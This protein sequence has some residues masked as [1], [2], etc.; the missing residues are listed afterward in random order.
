[1]TLAACRCLAV[2]CVLLF[3]STAVAQESK[4]QP[5]AKQLAAALDAAKLDS[6][7]APDPSTPGVFVGVLYFRGGQIL[8]VS[9][10]YAAP[11]AIE[12]KLAQKAYRD[13]YLDLSAG[14][15]VPGRLFV[16]DMGADGLQAKRQGAQ[17]F[18][19]VELDGKKVVLNAQPRPQKL[20]ASEYDTAFATAD[21]RYA[22]LLNALLA[23]LKK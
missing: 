7:A 1:M 8:A 21:E 2:S 3:P 10:K 9:T 23:Q 13:I 22:Q 19:S 6:L 17:A 16:E 12:Y 5:L 4:S 20:T 15:P 18:D 14:Q 11:A